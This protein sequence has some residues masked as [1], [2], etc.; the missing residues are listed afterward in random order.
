MDKKECLKILKNKKYEYVQ[1]ECLKKCD[2][3]NIEIN[4]TIIIRKSK[5]QGEIDKD[6]L[7]Q[8]INKEF[9]EMIDLNII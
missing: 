4:P 3:E 5:I 6:I 8:T 2:K 9:N 1:N 7:R